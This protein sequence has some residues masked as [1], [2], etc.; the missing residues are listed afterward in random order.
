MYDSFTW[1]RASEIYNPAYI[2]EDG[3]EPNDIN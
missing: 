3:I 2:F 1:R